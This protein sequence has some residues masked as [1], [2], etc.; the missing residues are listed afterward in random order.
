MAAKNPRWLPRNLVFFYISTSDRGDFPR[1]IEI[2]LLSYLLSSYRSNKLTAARIVLKQIYSF[3]YLQ[4][5]SNFQHVSVSRL[6]I[7][8]ENSI[9][10][11]PSDILTVVM[12]KRFGNIILSIE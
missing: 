7:L 3:L 4:S 12:K 2:A 10:I 5:T 11:K 6:V 8:N 1:N 9:N